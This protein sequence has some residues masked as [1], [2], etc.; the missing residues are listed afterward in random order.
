MCI[1]G[2]GVYITITGT[3]DEEQSLTDDDCKCINLTLIRTVYIAE[4]KS[5]VMPAI[6]VRGIKKSRQVLKINAKRLE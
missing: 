1:V 6:A 5:R 2:F 3:D 4:K